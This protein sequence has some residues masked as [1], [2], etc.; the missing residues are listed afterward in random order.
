VV[1]G[2]LHPEVTVE[3]GDTWEQVLVRMEEERRL[4]KQK[5]SQENGVSSGPGDPVPGVREGASGG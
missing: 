4:A 5:E 2:L 1:K 3:A